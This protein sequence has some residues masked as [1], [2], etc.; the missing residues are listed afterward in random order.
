MSMDVEQRLRSERRDEIEH[1]WRVHRATMW[2]SLVAWTGDRELS[3][4]AL[5]EAFAQAL[6]RGDALDTPDRW[7]W[8][9]AFR[10]AAGELAK[11]RRE[12]SAQHLAERIDELPEP[13][14]DLVTALRTLSPNQRTAAVLRLYA[15]LPT[16][17]VAYIL[18]CSQ[19]TVRVH[20]A[21]ARKRLRPLLEES[22]G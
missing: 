15:D 3:S 1:V 20:L 13:V 2:R 14:A 17:D 11:R 16:R 8:K 9:A 5:S 7:I 10:I 21:Q 18:G 12:W 6:G 22:D 19:T 4:D